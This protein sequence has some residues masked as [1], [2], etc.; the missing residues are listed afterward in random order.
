M[1]EPV[2]QEYM[3]CIRDGIYQSGIR[4]VRLE[5]MHVLL[6]GVLGRSRLPAVYVVNFPAHTYDL[7]LFFAVSSL[8]DEP[9]INRRR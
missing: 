5:C 7:S 8:V 6:G 9:A 1:V 2:Y 3:R 4:S